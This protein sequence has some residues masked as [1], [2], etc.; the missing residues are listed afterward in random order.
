MRSLAKCHSGY[1]FT[2]RRRRYNAISMNVSV[3]NRISAGQVINET[4]NPGRSQISVGHNTIGVL[5]FIALLPSPSQRPVI[6]LSQ[7]FFYR[8]HLSI[9]RLQRCSAVIVT[10]TTTYAAPIIATATPTA[11]IITTVTTA[12]TSANTT[13]SHP[14]PFRENG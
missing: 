6:L 14:H 12:T 13:P 1:T 8:H 11:V 5:D 10:A 4:T 3:S 7:C 2:L 9:C